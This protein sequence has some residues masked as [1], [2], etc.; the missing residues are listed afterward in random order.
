MA[1]DIY[2]FFFLD[3]AIKRYFYVGRSKDLPRRMREHRY[4]TPKGHED[5]YQRIRQLEEAGID[6]TSEVIERV[7]EADY[8]PDAERWH[9]IRLTREGH[10]LTNMRHGSREHRKELADQVQSKHIRSIADVKANRTRRVTR[11]QFLQSKR[12]RRRIWK[13]GLRERGIPDIAAD[14]LLPPVFKRKLLR[15]QAI[16]ESKFRFAPGWYWK[17]FVALVRKPLRPRT[18]EEKKMRVIL[19][20]HRKRLQ[21]QRVRKASEETTL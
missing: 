18:D 16:E 17:D 1:V 10:E 7:G 8:H 21:A 13:A 9:V 15:R 19:D 14:T 3:G 2:A 6:W 5:K 11:R 20:A 12:L 4:S